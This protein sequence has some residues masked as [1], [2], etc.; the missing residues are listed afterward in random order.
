MAPQRG[1]TGD[2]DADDGATDGTEW[3]E[4]TRACLPHPSKVGLSRQIRSATTSD[5]HYPAVVDPRPRDQDLFERVRDRELA[6]PSTRDRAHERRRRWR[7]LQPRDDL[8]RELGRRIGEHERRELFV[9]EA[10][11]RDVRVPRED[12]GARGAFRP[13]IVE[14]DA[15]QACARTSMGRD[16]VQRREVGRGRAL[17]R[18]PQEHDLEP[19]HQRRREL[20]VLRDPREGQTREHRLVHDVFVVEPHRERRA[21]D[22]VIGMREPFGDPRQPGITP[23]GLGLRVRTIHEAH[24]AHAVRRD[25]RRE[26]LRRDER[27]RLAFEPDVRHG[28]GV[29]ERVREAC[30]RLEGSEPLDVAAQLVATLLLLV[31][32]ALFREV[33]ARHHRADRV[34]G[35]AEL[36]HAERASALV[37]RGFDRL[38][39]VERFEHERVVRA[40]HAEESIPR[41][42]E[43]ARRRGERGREAWQLGDS[44][45]PR[46]DER[47]PKRAVLGGERDGEPVRERSD[48]PRERATEVGKP[49]DQRV[50][51]EEHHALLVIGEQLVQERVDERRDLLRAKAS[52]SAPGEL[53]DG[54]PLRRRRRWTGRKQ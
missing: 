43:R 22:L 14:E 27:R 9:V 26:P 34:F 13:T 32:F 40:M 47:G 36:E 24:H 19:R 18:A 1:D 39:V 51:L 50:R 33:R 54:V 29:R 4:Y 31:G 28:L 53:P 17:L 37:V 46:T 38:T 5:P 21:D 44:H 10:A 7:P 48:R 20:G 45:R 42:Q 3:G 2:D 8:G 41:A 25:E 16:G 52:D 49:E 6:L 12:L 15:S 35:R 30:A 23:S 11:T